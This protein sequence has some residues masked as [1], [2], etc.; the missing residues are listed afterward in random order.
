[1]LNKILDD[2]SN[3]FK[4]SNKYI[5][6]GKEFVEEKLI[7]EGGFGYVYVVLE[8][9]SG[10]KYALK[11]MN[12]L[13][14]E[15]MDSIKKEIELWSKINNHNNIVKLIDYEIRDKTINI[16]MELCT[17]GTLLEYINNSTTLIPEKQILTILN[18]ISSG[19]LYMHSQEK[20][21]CHRDLKIENVLK[22]GNKL[23]LCDFG[24][25]STQTMD[26]WYVKYY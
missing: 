3:F 17:E 11:K 12:I 8:P 7:G 22:F 6:N 1:M 21:I 4:V 25:A 26:P 23:K 10:V 9:S 19:I 14:L 15:A 5:V 24:S 18:D 16:L 20:P 2:M 13:S